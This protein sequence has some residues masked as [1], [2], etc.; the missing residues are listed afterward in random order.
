MNLQQPAWRQGANAGCD[1]RVESE[2]DLLVAAAG[3]FLFGTNIRRN[4]NEYTRLD[5]GYDG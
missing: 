3:R 5:Q 4:D 2:D 1:K